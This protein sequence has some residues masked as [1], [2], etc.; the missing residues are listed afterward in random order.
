MT[1]V[2]FLRHGLA[3]DRETWSGDDSLRPLTEKG[4]K[5][6][7]MLAGVLR[8]LNLNLDLI[9]TSPYLRAFQTAEIVAQ[10]LGTPGILVEDSRLEPGFSEQELAAILN[11]H[12]DA[13]SIMV[14][15]HEPD[16]SETVSA[17]IGGGRLVFKKAGLACVEMISLSPPQG[18]LIWLIPPRLFVKDL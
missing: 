5:K 11:D 4:K 13:R 1:S 18:E 12:S 15:G 16:F 3:E 7:A 8:D 6:L 14:V 10:E 17:L 9:L 2:H